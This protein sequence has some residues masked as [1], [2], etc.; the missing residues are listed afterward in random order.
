M[1]FRIQLT[2]LA[3]L[4][5]QGALAQT[6]DHSH[7]NTSETESSAPMKMDQSQM[8]EESSNGIEWHHHPMGPSDCGDMQVWDFSMGMCMPLTMKDMPMKMAMIHYNTFFTQT[9]EEGPRGRNT[10]SVPNM[11]MADIG[12]SIGDRQYI[13]LD[14]M[15]TLERWT[16]PENGTPELLQIGEENANHQPYIDAQHPHSSPIMGLT[17]SDTITLNEKDHVKLFFAPRGQATDGPVAFMHRPTGMVNPDAPLGH[18]IGQDVGHITSTVL[19]ASLRLGGTTFEASTFNGTEPEPSKVDLP[20]GALNSYAVRMT[21]LFSPHFYAMV[22]A[23]FVKNPEP[24]DPD[25]DHIWR[26]SASVYNDGNIGNGWMLHNSLIYGL[27]NFYD[28]TGALNSFAEEF[29]FHK[30]KKNIWSRIEYLQRTPGELQIPSSSPTD[31][32]WVTALT[33]GYTHKVAKWDSGD[34]GLGASITKDILPGDFRSSY[35]GDPLTGKVFLQV[36]G[37]KMW[38]L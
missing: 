37:M 33:L 28:N 3:L 35:G 10:F 9:S 25:L 31:A 11:F 32:K 26:Y 13:N 16:F 23:A 38:D 5:S 27:V 22:S 36:G 12:S 2:T 29:W 30:D 21:E 1:R 19:G 34:V 20:I 17:L 6:H 14:F 8:P 7:A 24:H 15:G 18:H 4:F